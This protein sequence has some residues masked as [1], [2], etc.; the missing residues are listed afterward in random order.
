[1]AGALKS[2]CEREFRGSGRDAGY[3]RTILTEAII[4]IES[5]GFTGTGSELLQTQFARGGTLLTSRTERW[6]H[7]AWLAAIAGFALL[8][9]MH[10]RADFPNHSPWLFDWAKYTDE[11]WYGNAAVRAHLFGNW[12][13]PGDFNPAVAVPVWPF[14][15]WLLFFFTGVTLHAARALAVAVFFFNLLLG[16]LLLRTSGPRWMALLALT[17]LVTS[18]FLYC[19]SRLAILEPMLTAFILAALNLAVR[20][21]RLRR[22]ARGAAC[23]GL[24]FALAMLTK[25]TAVF[26]LPA[27]A[28]AI[29]VPLWPTRKRAV[30]CLLAAGCAFV[31]GYGLWIG[32]LVRLHLLG[33]YRYY[34][35]VNHYPRPNEP[36]WPL[37]SLWW[38]IHGG[39]WVD[40]LLFP[41]AGAIVFGALVL[42]R[43]KRARELLLN[44][45]FGAS[46]LAI[47]GTILFM[48]YQNHPQPRYYALAAVFC[49]FLVALGAEAMRK[50]AAEG[51]GSTSSFAAGTGWLML[52]LIALASCMGAVRTI[53]YAAH[54]EYTFLNAARQLTRYIDDHPDGKRLLVSISGDQITLATHLP[55]LCDDF[56]TVDLPEKLEAYHPGW[57]AAWNDFDPGTLEDLHTHYS[58][59][60]VAE[61]PAFD[62]PDRNLLVLFK[63]HPLAGGR[64]RDPREQD[65][66]SP[67]P[68]DSFDMPMQ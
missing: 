30:V 19:F 40:S 13:L 41:L 31:A 43:D 53:G 20:L 60:Q 1:L 52:G 46:V 48:T 5:L 37:V 36:Y 59:E 47:A 34:F 64:V 17:L 57:Y 32:L 56:G 54:P 11:G 29:A 63:L 44:P 8:H 23:V 42:R 50:P 9:A 62:D 35:F 51:E 28:W 24:L 10:L 16:Y 18:P 26:M 33:D 49:F 68:D 45:V 25:T 58:I 7:A 3:T 21:P 38:S 67:L 4:A 2:G 22:P 6:L 55:T 27:V 14:C 65:L 12:Y 66:R 15:E 39:L 61:F